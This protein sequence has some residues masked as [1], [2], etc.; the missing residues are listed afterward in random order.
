MADSILSAAPETKNTT[1][2]EEFMRKSFSG[3]AHHLRLLLSAWLLIMCLVSLMG[4]ASPSPAEAQQ[5]VTLYG[6]VR[7]N[8]NNPFPNTEIQVSDPYSHQV[9]G[10]VFCDSAGVYS[11]SIP[12][13]TYDI[14]ASPPVNSGFGTT[15]VLSRSV[16]GDTR[17]DIVLVPVGSEY[18]SGR[19]LDPLGNGIP[20]QKLQIVAAGTS[21]SIWQTS[22]SQGNYLFQVAPGDY[23]L[24]ISGDNSNN[25][26]QYSNNPLSVNA[27]VEYYMNSYSILSLGQN[28]VM[29]I[30]LPAKRVDVHVQNP[31]GNPVADVLITTTGSTN[32]LTLGTLSAMGRSLYPSY[33]FSTQVRTNADGNATLWLFPNNPA[34]PYIITATPPPETD[35]TITNLHE[36]NIT[37]DTQ[38]TIELGESMISLSGRVLDPLG[39]G[40]PNQKLQIVAAGTSNSIW[41]TSDS[42]GNYL[43]QVA[44]GDYTLYI[45]GDNSNNL[46]QYSNNPLSVNA[47]V[48]Y[49]MNSYSILS[50][51]QNTVMDI[52]LPAKRVDVHVQNP[53]GNPVAD[54]LITTT[55]STNYLT[56]GTLSAMGRSLYPSYYFSTQV[57]TNADGN[58]TLWLFPN[59]PAQPYIITATP[60]PE[61][62]YLTFNVS[63]VSVTSDMSMVVVIEFINPPNHA[64]YAYAGE[65]VSISSE[66]IAAA[67][68]QGMVSDEDSSDALNCRW[69]KR[70]IEAGQQR[71]IVLLDWTPVGSN[72]QCE[73]WLSQTQLSIGTHT[74]TLEVSDEKVVSSDEMILTIG[75]SAPHAAVKGGGGT[76]QVGT[77]VILKG[78][79]SDFDGDTLSY[80]WVKGASTLCSG[81]VSAIAGGIPVPIPGCSLTGLSLGEHSVFIQVNDG[82]N[83]PVYSHVALVRVIDD[84]AP[85]LSP[86][87]SRTIL[88]PPN[89]KMVDIN[90]DTKAIDNSGFPVNINAVIMSNEPQDG[91]G[92]GDMSPDWFGPW[93]NQQTGLITLQLRAERSGSGKGR[94][95]SIAINATDSAGNISWATVS[96]IVP[97]D[98]SK[99]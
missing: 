33:Y 88:W 81:T 69:V 53:Q 36:V 93:V 29:D 87:A 35:Y 27:P 10:S 59:N 15:V 8:S 34:Q 71:E 99:K 24:Y 43:F 11:L 30:P 89:H 51:G 95:Y 70:W 86:V 12:E 68:I 2:E 74:L 5:I 73:L 6:T 91:L 13:G 98:Q 55:G 25:L 9:V 7:D 4:W 14:K 94:T 21:N 66:A 61:T 28:T 40:I 62:D 52:P 17:L 58:A 19:V 92:D 23:T 67:T 16:T 78:E 41:Q 64:P 1:Q 37:A 56:L 80:Q 82:I 42:Q 39:N 63:N 31:Q 50:L 45:S 57:R 20:N 72:G 49:Y 90:I 54:V 22:D 85:T 77:N 3:G 44:P 96:I 26:G 60:P 75:N 79:V 76:Y 84:I 83:N 48:E 32:Y 46:G 65:N 47:P 18:L 38:V 97:H